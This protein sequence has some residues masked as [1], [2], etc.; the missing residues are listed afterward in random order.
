MPASIEIEPTVPG[1]VA[2]EDDDLDN[3]LEEERDGLARLARSSSAST[4]KPSVR[5]VELTRIGSAGK[6]PPLTPKPTTLR[7]ASR[8]VA[9][10]AASSPER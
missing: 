10:A 7:P 5:S 9:A 1:G 8:S 6:V 2:G 4:A 3:L